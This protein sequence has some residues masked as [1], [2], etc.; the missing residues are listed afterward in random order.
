MWFRPLSVA[1]RQVLRILV[2]ELLAFIA[3]VASPEH[4]GTTVLLRNPDHLHLLSLPANSTQVH[5]VF[6]NAATGKGRMDDGARIEVCETALGYTTQSH[7]RHNTKSL[8]ITGLSGVTG[9]SVQLAQ[10]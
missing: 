8:I 5:L 3:F 1:D 4:P 10:L 6:S 7:K 9:S 2:I